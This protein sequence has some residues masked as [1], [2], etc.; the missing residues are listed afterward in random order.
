[1]ELYAASQSLNVNIVVHQ[2]SSTAPRFILSCENPTRDIHVS[3][4]GECHYNSV[5]S[6]A[7]DG[8]FT[9]ISDSVKRPIGSERIADSSVVQRVTRALPW[10]SSSQQIELALKISDN[11]FDAALELLMTNPDGRTDETA[12]DYSDIE[13]EEKIDFE[14]L[15]ISPRDTTGPNQTD[16]VHFPFPDGHCCLSYDTDDTNIRSIDSDMTRI[17]HSSD[18]PLHRSNSGDESMVDRAVRPI[19]NLLKK[20]AAPPKRLTRKVIEFH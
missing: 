7:K 11:N 16:I 20:V 6:T 13:K 14:Q 8:S 15:A 12:I 9:A 2:S 5:H 19:K 18:F 10:I 1:L 4:H 3:Y 17:V